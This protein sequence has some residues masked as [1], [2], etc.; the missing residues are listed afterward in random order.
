[1]PTRRLVTED[2]PRP[3]GQL[4]AIAAR[5][6]LFQELADHID[7]NVTSLAMDPTTVALATGLA[8]AGVAALAVVAAWAS[9]QTSIRFQ[10]DMA[11]EERLW[12]KRAELY[13]DLL[14]WVIE[15]RDKFEERP[16]NVEFEETLTPLDL[17]ARTHAFAS[18]RAGTLFDEG[19]ESMKTLST[20][21]IVR[22]EVDQGRLEAA[23]RRAIH[24][25]DQLKGVLTALT[26]EIR[27]ELQGHQVGPKGLP[28]RRTP[29]VGI[30]PFRSK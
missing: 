9:T 13:V 21:F 26:D 11:A 29:Y 3:L 24:E 27:T 20:L 8:S 25:W 23:Q 19:V 10:R 22:E 6:Q 1:L 16:F 5:C 28:P 15:T 2:G 7:A 17:Q 30:R 14:R 12:A 18:N 4:G